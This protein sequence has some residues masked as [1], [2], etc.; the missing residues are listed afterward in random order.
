MEPLIRVDGLAKQFHADHRVITAVDGISFEI[1]RGE[2]VGLVGESGCGKS[3]VGRC[4]LRLLTPDAGRIAFDGAEVHDASQSQLRPLRRRMQMVF[5]DPLGSLNPAFTIA[6]TLADALRHVGVPRRNRPGRTAELLAQVGLDTRFLGRRPRQMSGGQLQRVGI[7]RALASEP[8]FL[9]L[10]EP[11][12][13]LDLSVRGQIVNL[14]A[15][16]QEQ[17]GLAYLFA[18]HDLG[19][20]RFVAHRVIVMY[21]GRIVEE[22]PAD[23]IFTAPSH[24][25]TKALLIAAGIMEASEAERRSISGELRARSEPAAGC[26]YCDRCPH[27]HDHCRRQEPPLLH[28]SATHNSRCWLVSEQEPT[29]VGF[30][31]NEATTIHFEGGNADVA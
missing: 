17:R 25:Y 22:G 19:V 29:A 11:T 12:S 7:A 30:A 14:L 23:T 1:G 18:S 27:V 5:Q 24:P 13:S 26:L 15:D 10:D 9:F 20:V 6:Q 8:D 21:L 4:L 2:T 31:R 16:L 3:T 28:V